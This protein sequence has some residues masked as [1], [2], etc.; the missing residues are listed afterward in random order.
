MA[1]VY[2]KGLA[3]TA[4][5]VIAFGR[6]ALRRPAVQ[7]ALADI[8]PHIATW[9][10]KAME[11]L[12]KAEDFFLPGSATSKRARAWVEQIDREFERAT[13]PWPGRSRRLN[14]LLE[15]LQSPPKLTHAAS[16]S[17]RR[18]MVKRAAGAF[19][20][21]QSALLQAGQS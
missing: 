3:G 20:G 7:M 15:S 5:R 8:D 2:E 16:R 13:G 17:A 12:I 18:R 14:Q 1:P 19:G 10:S 6:T 21:V 4:I 11:C 9:W